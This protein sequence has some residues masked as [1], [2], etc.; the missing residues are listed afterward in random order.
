MAAR[1]S[2]SSPTHSNGLCPPSRAQQRE[3]LE[4][5]LLVEQVA[6][7]DLAQVLGRR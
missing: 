1:L 4:L 3:A 5:V 7:E 2:C 6:P